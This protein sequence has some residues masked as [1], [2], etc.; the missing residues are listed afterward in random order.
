M[1]VLDSCFLIVLLSQCLIGWPL[2]LTHS[3]GIQ[4][5]P[6]RHHQN[7]HTFSSPL[8]QS[9]S[10]DPIRAATGIR[11]SLHPVTINALADAFRA[12]ARKLADVPMRVN[13]SAQPLEV[14]VAAGK[15]AALALQ[16]R[17]KTSSDDGM[18]LTTE[19]EQTIAGR[20]VGVVMRFDNLEQH[21]WRKCQ[22]AAW[23][24]KYAEWDSF[25]VLVDESDIA[26]SI[27]DERITS[28]PLFTMNRAECVLAIFLQTVEAPA[29]QQ[30]NQT[31]PG[32]SAVDFL[33]ADQLEVL[34]AE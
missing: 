22:A 27:L 12:R 1:T 10:G 30:C 31:V 3:F 15:I 2:L 33:D 11:P 20:V 26:E 14:A 9:T 4:T 25:G 6:S 34:L 28:D 17:K 21:L 23:V 32:G 13:D 29:L 24:S 16:K 7:R 18:A 19:E 5:F 8:F